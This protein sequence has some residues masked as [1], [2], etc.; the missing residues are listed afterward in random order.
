MH[1]GVREA[2]FCS[3]SQRVGWQRKQLHV[4]ATEDLMRLVNDRLSMPLETLRPV[5][6]IVHDKGRY[7]ALWSKEVKTRKEEDSRQAVC[8]NE[9]LGAASIRTKGH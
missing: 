3:S 2:G 9:L 4:H 7:C 6:K 8:V 1:D 5:E